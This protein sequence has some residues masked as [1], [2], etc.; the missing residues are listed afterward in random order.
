MPVRE[1]AAAPGAAQFRGLRG[2][3]ATR[4][5]AARLLHSHQHAGGDKAVSAQSRRMGR[6]ARPPYPFRDSRHLLGFFLPV[7][8]PADE[9]ALLLFGLTASDLQAESSVA[10]TA[11]SKPDP[12]RPWPRLVDTVALG[13]LR[14][15]LPAPA[16]LAPTLSTRVVTSR[17]SITRASFRRHFAFERDKLAHFLSTSLRFRVLLAHLSVVTRAP[18]QVPS[19]PEPKR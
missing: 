6:G 9:S 15:L 2:Y 5:P 12:P 17:S 16:L 11:S 14:Q 10:K 3:L 19:S 13:L 7:P 8:L 4:R 18:L 1:D